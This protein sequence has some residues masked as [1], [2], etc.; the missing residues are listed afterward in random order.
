MTK[1]TDLLD[2]IADTIVDYRAGKIEAPTSEHV[3][4]WISQF[5]ADVQEPMLREL[6]HV[7][8][9]TY[10]RRQAVED[11]LSSLITTKKLAGDSP[12]AFWVDVRFLDIQSGGNSQHE[13][14][15]MFGAVLKKECDVEINN[16]GDDPGTYLYLDDAV[17]SGNRIRSDITSWIQSDAPQDAKVHVV[18]IA[19]HRGGQWYARRKIEEAAK[20]AGK[21]IATG[22]WRCIEIE[23]R[24]A[25]VNSSD[26]LR[27]TSIPDDELTEEYVNGMAHSPVLRKRGSVGENKFFSSE[28]GRHLLEQEFLKAGTRIRSMCPYFNVYQRP[29]GNMVLDTLGFGSLLVTFRNCPNSCPLAFWAG[30]PWY[31]LF[32]RK[33]N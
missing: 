29:L 24:K 5:P 27:P 8:K 20:A 28:E 19:L 25:Y 33:T 30:D 1:R 14:L 6:D 15:Q 32:P 13:M 3:D 22:W 12:C 4:A 10:F 23:D 11:F 7:L 17:F 9:R 26:V 16:C 2:S 31:P 21:R 18:T